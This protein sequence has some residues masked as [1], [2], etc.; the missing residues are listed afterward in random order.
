MRLVALRPRLDGLVASS[1]LVVLGAHAVAWIPAAG[2]A[3]RSADGLPVQSIAQL[4]L[5]A[6]MLG[7]SAFRST[8]ARASTAA[9]VLVLFVALAISLQLPFEYRGQNFMGD[10]EDFA[11]HRTKFV[12]NIPVAG[13]QPVLHLKA[14][15]GDAL[16]AGFDRFYGRS[17]DSPARAY[18]TVSRL[19]GLLYAIELGLVIA[20]FGASPRACRYA[21]LALAAPVAMGFYGY[22]ELGYLAIS[23]G[24]FPLLV[25]G[26][27]TSRM[28]FVGGAAMLQG[29]HAALHGFGLLG[30][31]G[32]AVT[33]L[34][35]RRSW[36]ERGVAAAR[37]SAMALAA[38]LVWI[39]VYVTVFDVSLMYDSAASNIAFRRLSDAFY[40]DRRLVQPL[41]SVGAFSE[42]GLA[43]LAVGVPLLVVSGYRAGTSTAARLGLAYAL[44][45]LLFLIAWWPSL[46][47]SRDMDLLLAAFPGV[48]AAA[49]YCSRRSAR[50]AMALA[51]MIAIHVVFWAAIADRS[52]ARVWLG[53]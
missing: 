18:R 17:E 10:G 38:Y 47:V 23:A 27:R 19:G 9:V 33:A 36:T 28:R 6:I 45:G 2:V 11:R 12:A 3:A 51:I 25:L 34:V 49:W 30:I 44:P 26:L 4:A 15:L 14:H 42:I 41:A 8:R 20:L 53:E 46:G 21:A 48:T 16:L 35:A 24:A 52:L 39:V 31:A 7:V 29:L 37:Y 13:D 40:F 22:Y 43:S 50:A 32:G 5:S 1:A